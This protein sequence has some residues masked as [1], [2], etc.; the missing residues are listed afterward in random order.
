MENEKYKLIFSNVVV[1]VFTYMPRT[2]VSKTVFKEVLNKNFPNLFS[3]STA[4]S[5]SHTKIIIEDRY[6]PV[7]KYI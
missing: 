4:N 7:V 1:V 5:R 6:E 2:A 3:I